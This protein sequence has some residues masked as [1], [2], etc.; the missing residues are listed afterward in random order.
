[1]RLESAFTCVALALA[2]SIS[3]Y[4]APASAKDFGAVADVEI[5]GNLEYK[6]IRLTPEIYAATQKNLADIIL[7]R[8]DET[9]PY[10]I[11][12]SKLV[13]DESRDVYEMVMSDSFVKDGYRYFDYELESPP[14]ND[15]RATSLQMGTTDEFVKHA[16]HISLEKAGFA[17]QTAPYPSAQ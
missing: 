11:N 9:V 14:E 4:A 13:S 6:A 16:A 17:L 3:A 1:M 12:N 10:F 15:I 7:C 8:G 2:L 5:S